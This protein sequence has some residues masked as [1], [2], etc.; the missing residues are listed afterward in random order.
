[1]FY[2]LRQPPEADIDKS[3]NFGA[4]MFCS[5]CGHQISEGSIF[6]KLCGNKVER[7][8][9][10]PDNLNSSA[11]SDFI[12]L[13]CPR[14]G[15][16]LKVESNTET[17]VCH[18]CRSEHIVRRAVTGV[19]LETFA[20]CPTCWWNDK[21]VKAT[22]KF[23][24]PPEPNEH[25]TGSQEHSGFSTFY[26]I[27]GISWFIWA[28]II[29]LVR[30]SMAP[31]AFQIALA[32]CIVLQHLCSS[33]PLFSVRGKIVKLIRWMPSSRNQTGKK[34]SLTKPIYR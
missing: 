2:L 33:D 23:G 10:D 15:G 11:S 18:Y 34:S 6:C 4:F 24:T 1:M 5:R 21:S 20:R 9:Q 29:F 25:L 3:I 32:F 27:G 31:Q 12:T 30:K 7:L 19:T 17:Q 14:C 26:L 22:L 28:M 16:K 8:N 13:N